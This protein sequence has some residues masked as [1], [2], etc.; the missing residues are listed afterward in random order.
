MTGLGEYLRINAAR[1]RSPGVWDCAAFPCAWAIDN[2]FPDPMADWRGRYDSEETA[3]D[4]IADAGSLESLFTQ[5]MGGAGLPLV[6]G[7]FE[8]GDIGVVQ[9]F[10]EQAGAVYTG[11]RWAFV[12]ERGLAFVTIRP[13]HV[14]RAWRVQNG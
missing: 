9:L 10:G 12:S 3:L 8:A 13:E 7:E 1:R 4:M 5:G 2:G 11:T 14:L 6:D